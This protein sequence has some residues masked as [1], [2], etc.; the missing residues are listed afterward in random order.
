MSQQEIIRKKRDGADL[1]A[2]EINAF[3]SGATNGAWADYQTS[4]LLMAMFI[5]GLS[6][7]EQNALTRAMLASGDQ[8]DFSDIDA[9]VA[10]KH[11]TGGVGDKT[12]LIIAP[13]V[14]AC[15]VSVPMISGRGLGH[16]GGTLDKLESIKGYNV[17]L[18]TKEFK[19]TIKNCGFAMSGQTAEIAPADKKLYALRDATA[20]VESVPLIVASIMS[21]KLAEGL[22][23]LVLDVKTG[24]GAFMQQFGD[25][26]KLAEAL[27]ETG[28]AFGVRCEAVISDMNQPLGKYVGN[29]SEVYECVKI[30]R[31]E[32]DDAMQPTLELAAE[33][34]AR[35]LTL[36]GVADSVQGSKF[37]VQSS[38][39]SG[40]ALDKFR[41]NIELQGGD[42]AVCDQ[43]ENLLDASLIRAEIKAETSGFVTEINA[44]AIG[45]CVSRIGGGRIKIEDQIDFAVGYRCEK[46]IGDEIRRGDALGVLYCRRE[47]Q[48]DPIREKLT[49]AYKI[50][51]ERNANDARLIKEIVGSF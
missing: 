42:P 11:S 50:S 39:D 40:A 5:N 46:K 24:S 38:L 47:N 19:R 23:A 29:A 22:D 30:L 45:E 27:V 17:N 9:P 35:I 49:A 18:T 12:S 14:A 44:S 21:K 31:G 15:G 33:L 3:V 13:L 28:K 8:L 20:T 32:A 36:C 10:D 48:I 7:E 34:A 4:A 2:P 16:T 25:A 43:P 41:Q 37:K 6:L 51:S 26:K 1:T